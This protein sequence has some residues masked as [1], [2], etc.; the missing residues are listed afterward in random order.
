M[1]SPS[2]AS[3]MKS[4]TRIGLSATW[5]GGP[6]LLFVVDGVLGIARGSYGWGVATIVIGLSLLLTAIRR[7]RKGAPL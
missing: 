6:G 1:G 3:T 2:R 5:W 7:Y 4:Q